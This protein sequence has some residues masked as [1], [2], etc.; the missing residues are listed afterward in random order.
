MS[1]GSM[2]Y[3]SYQV[4]DA[5]FRD[6]TQLR[7]AFRVHLRKVAEA[8]HKIEWNDSGDGAEGEDESIRACVGDGAVLE[9]A[10]EQAREAA[11]VL[12]LELDRSMVK[13]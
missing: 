12:R 11:E 8:M 2:N 10:I 3:L 1:G 5:T 7:K 4:E 13:S 9:S 6:N